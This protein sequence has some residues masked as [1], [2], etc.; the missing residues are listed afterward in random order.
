MICFCLSLR[1]LLRLLSRDRL[2]TDDGDFR[3]PAVNAT[4]PE[5]AS[6][7]GFVD[8]WRWLL[9]CTFP[10]ACTSWWVFEEETVC[11]PEQQHLIAKENHFSCQSWSRD[12]NFRFFPS[13]LLLLPMKKELKTKCG[14]QSTR[15]T[16]AGKV[17]YTK[18]SNTNRDAESVLKEWCRKEIVTKRH[19][20]LQSFSSEGKREREWKSLQNYTPIIV[21]SVHMCLRSLSSCQSCPLENHYIP[22]VFLHFLS[23]KNLLFTHI[24]W[25]F[26]FVTRQTVTHQDSLFPVIIL[27]AQWIHPLELF[28]WLALCA[29]FPRKKV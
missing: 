13:L 4:Q 15:H 11:L 9:L 7:S 17:K 12:F 5:T 26:F 27:F 28:S 22:N 23:E 21:P 18:Q 6:S 20:L 25:F 3:D 16:E 24:L 2:V 1:S 29:L 14:S 10:V 19:F 8:V